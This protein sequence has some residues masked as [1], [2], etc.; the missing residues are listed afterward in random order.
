MGDD[1]EDWVP[2]DVDLRTPPDPEGSNGKQE[3]ACAAGVPGL[4]HHLQHV[5]WFRQ[6]EVYGLILT[7]LFPANLTISHQVALRKPGNF[8]KL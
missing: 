6:R 1:I 2:R 3:P 5:L 8:C 4:S 7:S